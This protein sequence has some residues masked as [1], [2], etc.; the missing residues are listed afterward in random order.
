MIWVMTGKSGDLNQSLAGLEKTLNEYF[1]RK[2]PQLPKNIREVIVSLAPWV[3]III[4]VLTLPLVLLAF[5]LG[6]LVAPFS[7]LAGPQAGISYGLTYTLSMVVLAVALVFDI[8]AIPGL[9]SRSVKGWRFIYWAT[10]VS[11]VSNV[12][13]LNLVGGLVNV[14]ISFYFLFQIRELY[15]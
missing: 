8:L 15:K 6:A 13:S 10:L 2:A 1:G 7:F 4:L 9:F 12:I 14:V 5:G 3:N 11:L